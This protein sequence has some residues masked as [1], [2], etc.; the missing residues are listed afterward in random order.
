LPFGPTATESTSVDIDRRHARLH[1]EELHELGGFAIRVAP[2][3]LS[4]S[5]RA[6]ERS[7]KAAA[8]RGG[9]RRLSGRLG[10]H[11]RAC[12]ERSGHNDDQESLQ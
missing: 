1:A 3:V 8:A 12:A 5:I 2:L 7:S 11:R 10:L 9:F 4:G 6:R